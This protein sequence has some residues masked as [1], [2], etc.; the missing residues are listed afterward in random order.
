MEEIHEG[1][2]EKETL[3]GALLCVCVDHSENI[4]ET[5]CET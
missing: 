2:R 5:T 1:E 3:V 4:Y